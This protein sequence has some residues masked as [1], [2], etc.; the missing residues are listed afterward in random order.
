[1]PSLCS[2]STFDP[3]SNP[4]LAQRW[5]RWVTRVLT[6]PLAPLA[7]LLPDLQ[8]R[9]D[10]VWR[11]AARETAA[12]L[13]LAGTREQLLDGWVDAG[14]L[15]VELDDGRLT[16]ALDRVRPFA[17]HRARLSGDLGGELDARVDEPLQ[18]AAA[19]C[20]RAGLDDHERARVLTEVLDSTV[21]LASA[22][23]AAELR[24]AI[25]V[26]PARVGLTASDPRLCDPE[27]LVID[28]HPWHPMT[29][30]RVGLTAAEVLRHAADQ[31]ARTAVGCVDI[32]ASL[33]R[34]GGDWSAL[35][36]PHVGAPP[37]GFVRVPIHPCTAARL[38]ALFPELV[39]RRAIVPVPR[40]P[41]VCRSLLSLRTVAIG[42]AW[43]LKLACPMHTTSARRGVS[44]MSVHNGPVVS[45][46]IAS[47]QQRDP[48]TAAL[49]LMP[50][51]AA[52]GLE[53]DRVGGQASEL[54]AIL[55][56][57]P[58][59]ER[60]A[61]VVAGVGERWPTGDETVLE[62]ACIGYP[63]GRR[64]RVTAVLDDWISRLVPAALRM[65][66]VHGVV[67]ELHTQNTLAVLAD[68]RL[69]HLRVRDLGGIRIHA[70]RLRRHG[71]LPSF[72]PGSF[73]LTDDLDE[74]RSKLEHTL[75]H[76][77]L[78][79]LFEAA[80]QLGHDEMQAWMRVRDVIEHSYASWINDPGCD[81]EQRAAL[82]ADRAALLRPQVRAKALLRM[83]M[84]ERSSDYEYVSVENVLSR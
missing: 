28:G 11:G 64:E 30:S 55:R 74:V 7:D 33:V 24:R 2:G 32:E 13:L 56:E 83:R 58:S 73:I 82:E 77:H 18:I 54:G 35:A 8:A 68:G 70:P 27:H 75:F 9:L 60:T 40:A 12:R 79:S 44:P 52:A 48:I 26:A 21:N 84:H 71:P 43:H 66:S 49:E 80:A 63:G 76:A 53:P 31:L 57:V 20:D 22:R 38:P 59:P 25:A 10:V 47:M 4:K 69:A 42:P 39:R 14:A 50:E 67:L 6:G 62:R 1:M 51:P 46:L 19:I 81:D 23:L 72:A 65:L 36:E 61:W 3:L 45:R 41:L 5:R 34:Q 17:L 16:L 37:S 15:I 78:S 29:R